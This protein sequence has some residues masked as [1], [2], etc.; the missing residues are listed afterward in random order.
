MN[1]YLP[2]ALS[3]VWFCFIGEI[4]PG[5]P[6]PST[7]GCQLP[8]TGAKL[9]GSQADPTAAPQRCAGEQLAAAARPLRGCV[10]NYRGL[11]S[12]KKLRHLFWFSKHFI[13]VIDNIRRFLRLACFYF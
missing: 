12:P 2:Q 10:E 6:F 7:E 9:P 8:S 13:N 11:H 1:S 5:I 3:I 4:D